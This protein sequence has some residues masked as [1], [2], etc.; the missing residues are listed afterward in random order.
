[1]APENTMKP[2]IFWHFQGVQNGNI[3]KISIE[4]TAYCFTWND[5]EYYLLIEPL[6]GTLM[7]IWKSPYMFVFI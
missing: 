1:M 3:G 5:I 4:S 7:Q 6:K 2:K